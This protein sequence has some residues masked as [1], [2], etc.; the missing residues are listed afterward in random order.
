MTSAR[1]AA[2]LLGQLHLCLFDPAASDHRHAPVARLASDGCR[3]SLRYGG[4]DLDAVHVYL[5][6]NQLQ[7]AADAAALAGARFVAVD[8]AEGIRIATDYAAYHKAAQ[9]DEGD[10]NVVTLL[11]ANNDILIGRF[12]TNPTYPHGQFFTEAQ[13][14]AKFSTVEF[15]PDALKVFARKDGTSN[16]P[17]ALL[18]GSIFNA[19]NSR[20]ERFATAKVYDAYGASMIALGEDGIGIETDYASGSTAIK[21][22]GGGSIHVN[23]SDSRAISLDGPDT[24]ISAGSVYIASTDPS[25]TPS[26]STDF[27]PGA[28]RIKDPYENLPQ[29]IELDSTPL[30]KSSMAPAND[31]AILTLNGTYTL[32]PGRFPGGIEIKG[33]STVVTLVPN[34]VYQIGGSGLNMSNGTLKG[35]NVLLHIMK[36]AD[37]AI[38]VSGG[39]LQLTGHSAYQDIAIYQANDEPATIT[40]SNDTKIGDPATKKGG[41]LYMPHSKLTLQGSGGAVGTRLVA[42]SYFF[43]NANAPIIVNHIGPSF[44]ADK[45]YLVE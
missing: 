35:E 18:F 39:T 10:D 25:Y 23:S 12:I 15:L 16:P 31:N 22:N 32:E 33:G 1:F 29:L 20:I 41:V 36:T 9:E 8:Q 4:H 42:D 27:H 11:T 14:T 17:L 44:P 21:V 30:P 3:R 2:A 40:G 5:T 26:P 43:N 19:A 13:W 6:A 24:Q 7:N 45:S 28:D 38:H 37:G 34:G